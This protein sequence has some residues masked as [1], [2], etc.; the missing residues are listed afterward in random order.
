MLLQSL[1][2]VKTP[3]ITSD[4]GLSK[5]DTNGVSVEKSEEPVI[6]DAELDRTPDLGSGL[7][8]ARKSKKK[9]KSGF[10]Y[11]FEEK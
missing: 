3:E 8:S 11:E 1:D 10:Y 4:S 6:E 5:N 9:K 7:S 2:Q